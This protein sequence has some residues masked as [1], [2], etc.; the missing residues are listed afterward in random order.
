M[1]K[2]TIYG[3]NCLPV[4]FKIALLKNLDISPG[5]ISGESL[6]IIRKALQ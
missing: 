5:K 4:F 6:Q 2:E 1:I 3:D